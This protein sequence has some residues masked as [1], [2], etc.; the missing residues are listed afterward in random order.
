MKTYLMVN[1]FTR[2]AIIMHFGHGTLEKI[3]RILFCIK[4]W[5]R[6]FENIAQEL[7]NQ[8][9]TKPTQSEIEMVKVCR[10]L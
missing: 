5:L 8:Y 3:K 6:N 2:I 7:E 9:Y 1:E 10:L 4:N